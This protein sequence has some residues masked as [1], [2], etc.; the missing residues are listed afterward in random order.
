MASRSSSAQQ[1][2][3]ALM[4]S[5]T[6]P[7]RAAAR[8]CP[9][10]TLAGLPALALMTC[11]GPG[12]GH[13]A[14]LGVRKP[15]PVQYVK[16]CSAFGEGFFYIPGSDTCLKLG[17][18]FRAEYFYSSRF[19]RENDITGFAA[20]GQIAFDAR[21]ATSYGDLRTVVRL[22][23]ANV[24]GAGFGAQPVPYA[25]LG[26]ATT[27]TGADFVNRAYTSVSLDA[28]FIQFANFTAGRTQSFFEFYANDLSWYGVSGSDHGPTNLFAYTAT[29]GSFS[30]TLSIEDPVLRRQIVLGNA[31]LVEPPLAPFT[32]EYSYYGGARMPDIVANLRVEQG[33]GTAQISGAL[34]EVVYR[35]IVG[36]TNPYHGS[37][38]GYAVNA[39]AKFNLP[40]IAEGDN[41]TFQGTYGKGATNYAVGGYCGQGSV[42]SCTTNVTFIPT[43]DAVVTVTGDARL[44]EAF[45]LVGA[46]QHIWSQSIRQ[47]IFGSYSQVNYDRSLNLYNSRITT[48]GSNLIW[49][50]VKDL[51]IGAELQWNDFRAGAGIRAIPGA[52]RFEDQYV[53]R[54]RI[55]RDF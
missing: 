54:V 46:Y 8:S 27:A 14:D 30:S 22:Q 15:A 7:E 25:L 33:W 52:K 5:S 28:A 44:T 49:S 36:A 42:N 40:F 9:S 24:S 13:A 6:L 34:H 55:Q 53:S 10:F 48:I 20:L 4:D 35:Q 2:H 50:P 37:D 17:G 51:D 47:A 18:R 21:T 12:V 43:T 11:L 1:R 3:G 23:L 31:G 39:G 19:T 41:V 38:L 32:A 16:V 45:G 26:S 29:F